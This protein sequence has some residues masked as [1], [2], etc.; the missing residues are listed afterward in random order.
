MARI[1][2]A[3]LTIG[4]V[5]M[6]LLSVAVPAAW[7]WVDDD[8]STHYSQ[9]PPE[10]RSADPIKDEPP[11][12]DT[13]GAQKEIERM[14]TK[15]AD[16]LKE[17]NNLA[18]EKQQKKQDKAK[19]KE[20]CAKAREELVGVQTHYRVYTTN[21]QGE[22]VRQNEDQR[23]SRENAVQKRIKEFCG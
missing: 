11:K 17:R 2:V 14:E 21:E 4:L 7:K 3:A 16:Y 22:R 9:F 1:R 8:G 6:S 13:D 15:S 20:Y 23:K 10:D 12:V 19:R 18:A 5:A